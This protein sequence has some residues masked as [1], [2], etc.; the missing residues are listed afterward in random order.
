MALTKLIIGKNTK[1][2]GV[3]PAIIMCNPKNDYNVGGAQRA[4][5]N[6]GIEQVWFTGNRVSLE[7][8]KGR[9]LPREE[10][11]R[12]Y[13]E[14]NVIQ[15]DRPFDMF[16]KHIPI[17][18]MEVKEGSQCL[19]SFEHPK[20]A[21]YVFGPEDGSIPK[22]VLE[23][24]HQFVQIPSRHC[25]NVSAAI[26][27]VLYDRAMKLWWNDVAPLPELVEHRGMLGG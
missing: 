14:V 11:M 21:V 1:K 8:E 22:S 2:I 23:F 18:G 25:L 16:E 27:I 4:A 3:A 9:R 7:P 15:Y 10:R 24:C 19:A 26:N 13:D 17:I 12:G 20:D 5:S 6:F